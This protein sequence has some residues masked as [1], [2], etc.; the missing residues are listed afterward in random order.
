MYRK[1]FPLLLTNPETIYLDSASTAQKPWRVIEA[2][3]DIFSKNYANIHRWAYDLS[4]ASELLY[5]ASKEKVRFFLKAASRHEIIYTYNA[6]YAFNLLSRSLVKSG[7]LKKG[8]RIILSVLD[9]HA[10]IVPWQILEEEY[11]II[12]D[13]IGVTPDGRLDLSNLEEKISGAKLLSITAASNV[14]GARTDIAK[15]RDS[16]RKLNSDILF[17]VDGSQ[18]FPHFSVD[19]VD[20]DIDFFI[21]TG[22][23]VMSDTGLGI[24]Y[25]KKFLLQKMLPALCGGGAINGVTQ[26]GYEPAGLPYRFEPG[27]PHIAGA[28]SLLAALEYIES[29]GGYDTIVA[30]E[31]DLIDYVLSKIDT[32]PASIRLIG[33]K[34][35]HH[36]LGVFS[37]AF[38]DHHP[39]D[40]A[41]MLAEKGLCVRVWHHC[42]E[43]LHRHFGLGATL[44]MSLYIYNTK[45]DID[46][47]FTSLRATIAS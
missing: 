28:A 31:E 3:S 9:H 45:E 42:T 13:W 23:K 5:D 8:D 43:P 36:R 6:T 1:D 19:V 44:R 34:D 47:F 37:F 14:T 40:I 11:G 38:D 17:V 41:D 35:R 32:L 20:L 18:A 2:L 27:T 25:G 21:A 29:I 26:E 24:L 39:G 4:E 15:I 46:T 22:H 10:N 12:I 30:Y 7:M 33:P 16:I